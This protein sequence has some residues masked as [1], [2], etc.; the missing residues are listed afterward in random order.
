M[1]ESAAKC[2]KTFRR[3]P[4][5]NFA[6]CFEVSLFQILMMWETR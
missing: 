4:I 6:A 2:N 3:S 5:R 1:V